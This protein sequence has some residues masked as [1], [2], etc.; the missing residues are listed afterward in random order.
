M[1]EGLVLALTFSWSPVASRLSG[2]IPNPSPKAP[3]GI[4]DQMASVVGF[5]K[6]GVL[7]VIIVTA[8]VGVGAIAGGRVFSHHSA[9]KVGVSI[10]VSTV[11]ASVLYVGIYSFVTSITG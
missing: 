9:S 11:V 6:W 8:F 2:V 4:A 10:L 7:V 1:F 3:P 5:V